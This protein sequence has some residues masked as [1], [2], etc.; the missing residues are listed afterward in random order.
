MFLAGEK[1]RTAGLDYCRAFPLLQ[2]ALR[3]RLLGPDGASGMSDRL[4]VVAG[5]PFREAEQVELGLV[6]GPGR[7]QLNDSRFPLSQEEG[8]GEGDVLHGPGAG[9]ED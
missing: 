7:H 9:P 2:L 6:G 1:V 5:G 4:A 3:L 8:A